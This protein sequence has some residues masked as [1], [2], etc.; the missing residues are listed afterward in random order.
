MSNEITK[1][2]GQAAMLSIIE[3]VA[4]D[5]NVDVAKMEKMLDMQERIF[6][7]NA[8]IAFNK[9]MV[10]CQQEMPEV[11][12]DAYNNQTNSKYA[13]FENLIKQIKPIYTKHGFSLS[14]GEKS[15]AGEGMITVVCDVRHSEGHSKQYHSALPIDDRGIKGSVNKTGIHG[16]ASAYSYAKRYL[17][18]M[19]FNIAVA[20]HDDDGVA[21][22]GL[23][24]ERMLEHNSAVRDLIHS[25][26]DIKLSI[27][28]GDL[29]R[30][31]ES[32]FAL[33]DDEKK[34]IWFA[35]SKGGMFTTKE[36]EVMKSREFRLANGAFQEAS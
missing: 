12:A 33:T 15:N 32:W 35:P 1:Q 21:A 9:A 30:G 6:D 5:P 23:T 27:E 8:E 25:I 13:T 31:S 4:L 36:R 3:K 10:D 34:A 22:G 20:D 11:I 29:S 18:T 26:A 17:T 7:K 14:F 28:T 16:T 19:I 24:I 2:D